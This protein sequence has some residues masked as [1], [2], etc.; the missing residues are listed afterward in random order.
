MTEYLLDQGLLLEVS[1]EQL[2][3][4]T[5]RFDPGRMTFLEGVRVPR[6]VDVSLLLQEVRQA[7]EQLGGIEA[8]SVPLLLPFLD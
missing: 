3:Q 2:T 4:L 5:G 1:L 6:H 8:S 7:V